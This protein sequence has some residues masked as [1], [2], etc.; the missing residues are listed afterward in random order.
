MVEQAR[1]V[2]NAK[3][4]PM[5][6]DAYDEVIQK[7][8]A[9]LQQGLPDIYGEQKA[10][11]ANIEADRAK[12][13]DM[14][15]GLAAFQAGAAMLQGNQGIRGLAA[16][17][18]TFGDAYGAAI[19]AD[20]AQKQAL[21]NMKFNIADSQRKEQMGLMKDSIAAA[22]QARRD[23]QAMQQFGID[24]AKALGTVYRGIAMATRPGPAAKTPAAPKLPE[25]LAQAEIDAATNPG[26]K[27]AQT[28]VA[29]LRKAVGQTKSSTSFSISDIGAVRKE[30]EDNKIRA[31]A[32]AA[33]GRTDTAINAQVD[34]QALLN[35]DYQK[36]LAIGDTDAMKAVKDRMY[37]ETKERIGR[38]KPAATTTPAATP[39]PTPSTSSQADWNKK[40]ATLKSGQTMVGLDGVTYTKK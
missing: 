28:R 3:Y 38:G 18:S 13:L 26:N 19:K 34:K 20:Q 4:E 21:Q 15:K 31:A 33:E 22:D 24:K 7:R 37:D 8:M 10:N 17:A 27:E 25:L 1:N 6:A 39:T 35:P 32:G 36:A 14:A 9:A 40:W 2:A 11:V 12:N 30:V 16:G 23:H 5:S 29:A